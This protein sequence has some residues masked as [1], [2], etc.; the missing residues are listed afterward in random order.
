[1]ADDRLTSGLDLDMFHGDPLLAVAAVLVQGL[2]L[3]RMEIHQFRGM[4]QQHVLACNP[5]AGDGGA[6]QR[7]LANCLRRRRHKPRPSSSGQNGWVQ[8]L[9][10]NDANLLGFA[11]YN[12]KGSELGHCVQR[13]AVGSPRHKSARP[14]GDGLR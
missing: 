9:G 7:G 2:P 8:M 5:L 14:F 11:P 3:P 13:E 1:M 10:Q 12:P 4:F 6:A